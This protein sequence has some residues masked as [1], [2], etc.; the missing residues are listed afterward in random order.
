VSPNPDDLRRPHCRVIMNPDGRQEPE[1][2]PTL[3]SPMPPEQ[4]VVHVLRPE[5]HTVQT[6]GYLAA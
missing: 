2:Q 5:E 3:W 1:D 6:S 4:S